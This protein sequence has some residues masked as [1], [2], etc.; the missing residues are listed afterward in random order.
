MFRFARSLARSISDPRTKR[1]TMQYHTLQVSSQYKKRSIQTD[2]G[3]TPL[4]ETI[5][6]YWEHH[7]A[8]Y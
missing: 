4:L 2:A 6:L 8:S 7:E 5:L 3:P 1:D